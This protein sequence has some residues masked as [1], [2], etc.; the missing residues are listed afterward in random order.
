MKHWLLPE[1][2]ILE[3]VQDKN[4][5]MYTLIF[6]WLVPFTAYVLYSKR[7]LKLPSLLR[8]KKKPRMNDDFNTVYPV[9]TLSEE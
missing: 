8:L 9:N 5:T 2:H 6:P 7:P 3:K 1:D 4:G